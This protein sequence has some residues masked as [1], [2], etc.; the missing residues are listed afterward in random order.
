MTAPVLDEG[1]ASG[2]VRVWL[3]TEGLVTLA[4]SL[5]AYRQLGAKWWI[6]AVL[7]LTPDLSILGYL[8]SAR[9]GSILYNVVHSYV[10][11]LSLAVVA[12]AAHRTSLLWLTCIWTAHIGLDRVLGFGL[13]YPVAF[14]KTHLGAMGKAAA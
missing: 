9:I 5:L 3:R 12:I 6:L 7:F 10:L 1:V 8:V 2:A 4:L 13:K 14:G 11:P